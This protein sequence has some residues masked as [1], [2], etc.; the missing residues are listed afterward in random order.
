MAKKTNFSYGPFIL[1]SRIC[2][3]TPAEYQKRAY[4]EWNQL[5]NRHPGWVED[6]ESMVNGTI[7]WHEGRH[8][9][10]ISMMGIRP[11]PK[12][13]PKHRR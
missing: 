12:P 6:T 3:E 13:L 9:G 5:K 4:D 1:I 8:V 11:E 10:Y 2:G 7:L